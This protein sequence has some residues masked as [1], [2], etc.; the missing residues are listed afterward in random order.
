MLQVMKK[1]WM[2][3]LENL[4]GS[5]GLYWEI[6]LPASH[7]SLSRELHGLVRHEFPI[8]NPFGIS[9][10]VFLLSFCLLLIN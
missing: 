8:Q 4:Y 7:F 10:V 1:L 6:I 3:P 9:N 5:L 2:L